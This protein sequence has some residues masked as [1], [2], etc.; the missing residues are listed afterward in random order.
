MRIEQV[1][2][3]S[4]TVRHTL[5]QPLLAVC[6]ILGNYEFSSWPLLYEWYNTYIIVKI[7]TRRSATNNPALDGTMEYGN[8]ETVCTIP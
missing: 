5:A 7:H 4:F 8:R 2:R 3:I 6:D 1:S